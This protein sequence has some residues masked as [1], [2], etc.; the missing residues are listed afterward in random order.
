MKFLLK[1]K[2]KIVFSIFSIVLVAGISLTLIHIN[3]KNKISIPKIENIVSIRMTPPNG[4]FY[5]GKELVFNL[6]KTE[7]K[8]T[9]SEILT[10][11]NSASIV[12]DK[13][14]DFPSLG[15][16]NPSHLEIKLKD[17]SLLGF[18]P[19][20]E[21]FSKKRPGISDVPAENQ[22]SISSSKTPIIVRINSPELHKWLKQMQSK[23]DKTIPSD[24]Q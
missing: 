24:I 15:P 11:L 17:K 7:D 6:N 13:K 4:P 14:F 18:S 16:G 9:I 20:G 2:I 5:E 19:T 3:N 21:L 1:N 22:V 12:K 8:K 23:M 10:W